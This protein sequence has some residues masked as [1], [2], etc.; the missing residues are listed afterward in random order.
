MSANLAASVMARLKGLAVENGWDYQQVQTRY[1]TERFLARLAASRFKDDFVLKGGNMFIVWLG[2]FGYRAT[3]DTDFLYRGK[4][5]AAAVEAAFRE[6]ASAP[7]PDGDDAVSFDLATLR[8]APIRVRTR[9]GGNEVTLLARI[10]K[11]RIQLHFDIGFGDH[12]WPA[13]R[14]EE[15]PALLAA[16]SP[17]VKAYPKEASIA[18]KLRAMLEHGFENSRM[19]DFY[20]VWLL[21]GRYEFRYSDLSEAVRQTLSGME[22]TP[23]GEI[24]VAFTDA[25]ANATLKTSQWAGFVTRTRIR[26]SAPTLPV[27]VATIRAF[28]LPVLF[29][30]AS[31]PATWLPGKGW[32]P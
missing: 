10:A 11:T 17:C 12:V 15:F 27:A 14:T 1:A 31:P 26:D 21:A 19:K 24:P 2:G 3:M 16:T 9:Y 30:P 23:T 22:L 25:F 8:V 18:E 4:S 13:I 29:P 5:D 20:D 28:L 6:I 32:T 7:S